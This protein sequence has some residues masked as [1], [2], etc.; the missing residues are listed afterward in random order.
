MHMSGAIHSKSKGKLKKGVME[1]GFRGILHHGVCP[2]QDTY[3]TL[4][5][6]ELYAWTLGS[7]CS[8]PSILGGV[9]EKDRGIRNL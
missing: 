2:V 8:G 9:H 6:F 4:D 7:A 1:P 5:S 3:A